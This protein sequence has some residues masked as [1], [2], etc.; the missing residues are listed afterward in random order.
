MSG[1]RTYHHG[2]LVRHVVAGVDDLDAL[3]PINTES[4]T[5]DVDRGTALVPL[6]RG[7]RFDRTVSFGRPESELNDQLASLLDH[8]RP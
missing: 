8:G 2:I 1:R 7:F 5:Q 4:G 6:D 3:T